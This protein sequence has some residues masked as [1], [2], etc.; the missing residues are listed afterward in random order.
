MSVTPKIRIDRAAEEEQKQDQSGIG[1]AIDPALTAAEAL[2]SRTTD[3]A[4]TGV[5]EGAPEG[6]AG[7]AEAGVDVVDSVAAVGEAA[8]GIVDAIT[9]LL[10]GL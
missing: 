1:E 2:R 9:G 8:G 6:A 4:A 10:D 7:A 5:A 3:I